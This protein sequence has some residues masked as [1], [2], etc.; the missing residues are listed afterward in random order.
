[1]VPFMDILRSIRS[2]VFTH[3]LLVSKSDESRMRRAYI[4]SFS[5]SDCDAVDTI[6]NNSYNVFFFVNGTDTT[7]FRA[8]NPI[9]SVWKQFSTISEHLW[10]YVHF[11][12]DQL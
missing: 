6:A 1:M 5:Q 3:G 8:Y 2:T 11:L 4:P 7:G 10:K 9:K 12:F